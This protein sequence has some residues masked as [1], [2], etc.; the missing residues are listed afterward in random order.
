MLPTHVIA[1]GALVINTQGMLL[2]VRHPQRGWEFPGGMA[3][4]GE[5]LPVA[6]RREV[7]E[8]TGV[9]CEPVR[10]VGLYSN[11]SIRPGY[12]GVDEIPPILNIDFCCRYVG[13]QLHTSEE[14]LEVGWFTQAEAVHMVTHPLLSHLLRQMLSSSEGTRYGAFTLPFE[15]LETR[16]F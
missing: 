8:E 1:V 11:L 12:N 3:E 14:S 16:L 9:I 13:G 6:L 10:L 7:L 4:R 15:M 5:S 2:L